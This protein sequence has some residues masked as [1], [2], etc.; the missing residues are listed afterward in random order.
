MAL[1]YWLLLPSYI[2]IAGIIFFFVGINWYTIETKYKHAPQKLVLILYILNF[3]FLY[4]GFDVP[5]LIQFII[6]SLYIGGVYMGTMFQCIGLTGGIATGKSTVSN[7]LAENGFDIID[8]DKISRDVSI[9]IIF[10]IL[11]MRR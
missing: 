2:C 6:K 11:P 10:S 5:L 8:A 7:I 3:L 4:Y 9:V 1:I